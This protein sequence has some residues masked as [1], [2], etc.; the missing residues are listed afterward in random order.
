[1]D[2]YQTTELTVEKYLLDELT[3]EEREQFEEHFFGCHE[4]AVDLRATDA[5]ITAAKHEFTINPIGKTGIGTISNKRPSVSS[6]PSAVAWFALAA[7]LLVM[8]YQNVMVFPNLRNQ[9]AALNVPEVLPSLSL[10]GG[11]SRGGQLPVAEISATRPFLLQV[12]IPT[13]D[14]FSSYTCLWYSPSGSLSWRTEVSARAAQDTVLIRVPSPGGTAGVYTLAV[15]GNMDRG[16]TPVDLA[17][18]R[19]A[20]KGHE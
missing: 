19:F 10:V 5:F 12:D 11:N 7:S 9:V 6:W 18:Y 20:L 15:Q 14:R 1:M 13:Q 17:H 16:G 8:T 3:L 2:H 4:C